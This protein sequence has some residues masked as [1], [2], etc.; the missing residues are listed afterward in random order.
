MKKFEDLEMKPH[1][2]GNGTMARVMFDNGYGVSV[3]RF[4]G[5][6]GWDSGLYELAVLYGDEI[7]YSTDIT[8]D[9]IGY[10]TPENVTEIMEK[11]QNL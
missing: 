1:M 4:Q 11:V 10:L 6:Y 7:C 8:D 2:I 3:I 9:V 5:S